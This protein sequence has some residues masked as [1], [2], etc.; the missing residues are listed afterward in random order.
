MLF[1]IFAGL[2]VGRSVAGP[3]AMLEAGANRLAS[4]DFTVPIDVHSPDEFGLLAEQFNRLTLS[5][6]EHQK[7]LLQAERLASIGRLAAGVAHEINNPLGVILGYVRIIRKNASDRLDKDLKII[8]DEA[9]RCQEIVEGLLDLA[10]PIQ[11]APKAADLRVIAEE[12]VASLRDAFPIADTHISIEG[13]GVAVGNRQK[14]WQVVTNL[15]KNAAEA[16]GTGGKV[17][18]TIGTAGEGFVELSVADD[19]PG[20]PMSDQE[21]LF[22]PFYSTKETGTGLGLAVSRAI[23]QAHGGSLEGSTAPAGGAVFIARL[24]AWKEESKS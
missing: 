11:G 2:I 20:L 6:A 18:I 16:S 17:R 3:I 10:R 1:A 14:I 9:V 13:S 12:A 23:V 5:L 15:L 24:P 21:R 8:E 19:G 4:G 22:E 7:R